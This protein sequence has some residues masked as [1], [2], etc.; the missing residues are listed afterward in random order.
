MEIHRGSAFRAIAGYGG[1]GISHGRR[2]FD[3]AGDL[4]VGTAFVV[5][6]EE[7]QRLL[8][9]IRQEDR[10]IVYAKVPVEPVVIEG[11]D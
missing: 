3:L 9:M 8:D 6:G 11:K 5:P 10:H 4:S 7:T 2:S 1:R